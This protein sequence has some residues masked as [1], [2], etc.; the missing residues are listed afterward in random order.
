MFYEDQLRNSYQIKYNLSDYSNKT[1]Y[2][3]YKF[4]AMLR[5]LPKLDY[6][7]IRL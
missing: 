4:G 2:S 7:N 1:L 5:Q 6:F 3:E